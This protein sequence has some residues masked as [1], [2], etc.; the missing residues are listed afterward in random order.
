MPMPHLRLSELNLAIRD[1][2]AENFDESLWVV[3]E[4]ARVNANYS[5]HTY[6]DLVEKQGAETLAQAKATIWR[7]N[8]RIL[9]EYATITGQPLKSGIQVL[10]L[11][12]LDYHPVYGLSLNV[13]EID[14]NYTLGEMARKR[15][16]ILDRLQAE[17]LLE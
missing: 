6:L 5:G 15:Q 1:V 4:I 3:A 12:R 10:L 17:G 2:L 14:P 13:K 9:T 7:S 16:E 8:A 11:V